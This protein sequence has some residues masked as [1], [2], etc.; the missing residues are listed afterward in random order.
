MNLLTPPAPLVGESK[1]D[2]SISDNPLPLRWGRIKA[3]VMIKSFP[4]HPN[5]LPCLRRSGFA[6]AGA[7]GEG[8]PFIP[9][10]E[11]GS[12]LAYS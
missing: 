11:L 10:A 2:Q 4:P 1:G 12:I 9:P 3:G 8:K 7:R 5:P 6:Q